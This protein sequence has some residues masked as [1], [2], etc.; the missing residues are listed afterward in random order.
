MFT[1]VDQWCKASE[2]SIRAYGL[3]PGY[4]WPLSCN[5]VISNKQ[6]TKVI[7]CRRIE[8]SSR[9]QKLSLYLFPKSCR[10]THRSPNCLIQDPGSEPSDK[11]LRQTYWSSC[12]QS[13]S[14][15]V[16]LK[17]AVRGISWRPRGPVVELFPLWN[18]GFD[19]KVVQ[20]FKS[21]LTC[22]RPPSRIAVSLQSRP[23]SRPATAA[24]A[25]AD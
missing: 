1:F 10:R 2:L 4:L 21:S 8:L 12:P 22:S 7:S 23:L 6:H 3:T 14:C 15:V 19:S 25:F 20:T 17:A 18:T 11:W 5:L 9:V 24:L 13:T 16:C